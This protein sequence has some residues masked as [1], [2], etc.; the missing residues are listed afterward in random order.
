MP[1]PGRVCAWC[2]GV[3]CVCMCVCVCVCVRVRVWV[4]VGGGVGGWVSVWVDGIAHT[5]TESGRRA[6]SRSRP[7]GGREKA[8]REPRI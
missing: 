3:V 6:T 4:W 7:D 2:G 5:P 1:N 8:V